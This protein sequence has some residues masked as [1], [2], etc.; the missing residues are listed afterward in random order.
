MRDNAAATMH[1]VI[2]TTRSQGLIT[3][4]LLLVH[5]RNS[6]GARSM[7]PSKSNTHGDF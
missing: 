1:S 4:L 3:H 2:P 5:A 6:P 7:P